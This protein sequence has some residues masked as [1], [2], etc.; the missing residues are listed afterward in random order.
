M[1]DHVREFEK[2]ALRSY[3]EQPKRPDRHLPDPERFISP[4]MKLIAARIRNKETTCLDLILDTM[5]TSEGSAAVEI[6]GVESENILPV[7][8]LETRVLL[9]LDHIRESRDVRTAAIT[10]INLVKENR[11]EDAFEIIKMALEKRE[12]SRKRTDTFPSAIG[13][14]EEFYERMCKIISGEDLPSKIRTGFGLFEDKI[15]ASIGGGLHR[16]Q[17]GC[18]GA[19][20]GRG[21]SSFGFFLVDQALR[22]NKDLKAVIFSLEMPAPDVTKKILDH[23]LALSGVNFSRFP[24]HAEL[25]GAICEAEGILRRLAIDDE[26]PKTVDDL[27]EAADR[28]QSGHGADLF[29]L[30]YIQIINCGDIAAEQLRIAYSEAVRKLTEDAKKK[31]RSWII[32]SQFG[33]T[34]EGRPPVMADLKETS[35]IEENCHWILGLHREEMEGGKKGELHPTALQIHILKNRYGPSGSVGMFEADWKRNNFKEEA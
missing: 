12:N 10:A 31:N 32:L 15:N 3:I 27:I 25:A 33:R 24:T 11:R 30:D 6:F 14:A 29:L 22:K 19:R 35:A 18:I 1:F 9:P 26:T 13:A 23:Q 34:A 16:G 28:Y 17:I 5:Q 7:Q 2:V 21:K 20:P 8:S 4:D